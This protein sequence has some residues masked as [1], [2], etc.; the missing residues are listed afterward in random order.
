MAT[1][2]EARSSADFEIFE[3][4]NVDTP[5]S[6]SPVPRDTNESWKHISEDDWVYPFP[7]DF[8]LSEHAI[9][10]QRHLKVISN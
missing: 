4:I 1:S 8:E 2:V 5:M 3:S 10:E 7:T 6:R 9:D